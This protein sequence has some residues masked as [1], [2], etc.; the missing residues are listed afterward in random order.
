MVIA[1]TLTVAQALRVW[2]VKNSMIHR[3]RYLLCPAVFTQQARI[4]DFGKTDS[5]YGKVR[6][7]PPERES[8]RSFAA[9][10]E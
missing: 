6:A 3:L 4:N 1:L 9:Q 2:A 5:M 8:M 10:H 7:R